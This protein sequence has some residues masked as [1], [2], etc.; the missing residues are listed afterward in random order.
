MEARLLTD[1][2]V[3]LGI[4]GEFFAKVSG[5]CSKKRTQAPFVPVLGNSARAEQRILARME[6][7]LNIYC[8]PDDPQ[9]PLVC[10][11]EQPVQLI[12]EARAPSSAR[13][14]LPPWEDYEYERNG[15]ANTLIF[16]TPLQGSPSGPRPHCA[17]LQT[18]PRRFNISWGSG[19]P[20]PTTSD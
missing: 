19:I 10:M 14:G 1:R 17:R 6:D 15:T 3:E 11:D 8:G 20:R 9:I 12:K 2:V 7:L 18:G 4:R 16:T 5:V 13:P